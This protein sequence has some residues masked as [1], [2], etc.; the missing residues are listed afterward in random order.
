GDRATFATIADDPATEP[1]EAVRALRVWVGSDSA[2]AESLLPRFAAVFARA[3][4][5]YAV[6]AGYADLLEARG[7]FAEA[8]RATRTWI[9]A[10]DSTT[11]ALD[12]VVAHT[13]L[14]RL[15]RKQGRLGDAQRTMAP[16][17]DDLQYGALKER[18]V[19]AVA[20]G[21]LDQAMAI[22]NTAA[23]RYPDHQ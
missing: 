5:S 23:A 21:H 11:D 13:L 2:S 16:F 6:M 18:A 10:A 1:R 7:R 8:E 15:Q 17:A 9:A 4:G 22:A 20:E 3:P 14:A 12:L 19:I